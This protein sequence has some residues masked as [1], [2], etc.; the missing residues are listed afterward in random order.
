M[1]DFHSRRAAVVNWLE[2][3]PNTHDH[4]IAQKCCVLESFVK[5]ERKFLGIPP[6]PPIQPRERNPKE[7]P[8]ATMKLPREEY[9]GGKQAE[10]EDRFAEIQELARAGKRLRHIAIE[11][12]LSHRIIQFTCKKFGTSVQQMNREG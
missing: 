8:I 11:L 5:S 3:S 4:I 9:K 1:T 12:G 2:K 7:R 10:I 6:A